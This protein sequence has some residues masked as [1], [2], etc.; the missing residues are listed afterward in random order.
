MTGGALQ[1]AASHPR[2]VESL[3]GWAAGF[4]RSSYVL[5]KTSFWAV[6]WSLLR[7]PT[8]LVV[9]A[10]ALI[11]A[12]G[13]ACRR[14]PAPRWLAAHS[15]AALVLA[16]GFLV[17][18]AVSRQQYGVWGS[19]GGWYLWNWSPWIATAASDLFT[20]DTR[21]GRSLLA[22]ECL[23]VAAANAAWFAVAVPH[24]GW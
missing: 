2:I 22:A 19:V 15:A 18:A 9:F 5:V 21:S 1:V 12:A 24:F 23:F 3:W 6:G 14:A 20:I 8:I 17:F 7:P 11:L 13:W 16:A 10:L 4:A